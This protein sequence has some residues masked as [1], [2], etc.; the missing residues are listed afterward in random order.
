M[1]GRA[2]ASPAQALLAAP[3]LAAAAAPAAA[4]WL[5]PRRGCWAASIASTSIGDLAG[6]PGCKPPPSIWGCRLRG[7]WGLHRPAADPAAA[8]TA[9]RRASRAPRRPSALLDPAHVIEPAPQPH[10]GGPARQRRLQVAA[11]RKRPGQAAPRGS[12]RRC[13]CAEAQHGAQPCS[14]GLPGTPT[15]SI[16]PP[17]AQ[18][19][20]PRP[21]VPRLSG[22]PPPPFASCPPARPIAIGGGPHQPWASGWARWSSWC[23]RRWGSAPCSS[24]AGRSPPS[25]ELGRIGTRGVIE[26]GLMPARSRQ[27]PPP[28]PLTA[29]AAARP[30]AG[31][32]TPW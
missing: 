10:H 21:P 31:S 18:L 30:A 8:A 32:I 6:R 19:Q 15:A 20:P 4:C 14:C 26:R 5:G 3:S 12:W 13:C 24:A 1:P 7:R 16:G 27:L 22:R 17:A 28:P 25:C 23:S 2:E 29:L 11:W 9:R